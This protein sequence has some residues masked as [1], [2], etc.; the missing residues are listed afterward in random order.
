[1]RGGVI[2]SCKNQSILD[3]FEPETS[4]SISIKEAKDWFENIYLLQD[5][6]L[7]KSADSKLEREVDWVNA[8]KSELKDEGT[9]VI[10]PIKYKTDDKPSFV[11]WTNETAYIE[12]LVEYYFN[13][14]IEVLIVYTDE[15]GEKSAYL[16]QVAYDRYHLANEKIDTEKF[17]G[18]FLKADW[19]DNLLEANF[20]E[21]GE[22][23]LML[24]KNDSKARQQQCFLVMTNSYYT[25][26]GQSCG[27][28]CSEFTITLHRDYMIQCYGNGIGDSGG[29]IPA[30]FLP[31]G[32]GGSQGSYVY[33][34]STTN[35]NLRDAICNPGSSD[36]TQMNQNLSDALSAT[37][38]ASGVTG[39]T[40][41]KAE[42]ILKS[43]G[44]NIDD[45][46][47][48]TTAGRRFGIAGGGFGVARGI[49]GIF[50][51]DISDHDALDIIGGTIS[52]G[53][54]VTPVG[55]VGVAVGGVVSLA[56]AIY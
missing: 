18:W 3:Y 14:I 56:I 38:L 27:P 47:P 4:K 12:K 9:C 19:D 31:G 50:D 25:Y 2:L 33:T 15:K 21:N 8:R 11:T 1:M 34:T 37:G 44:A 32:S 41:N 22:H 30:E 43:I 39:W 51:G 28:N 42:A 36:R 48:L 24:E 55:W 13:P 20:Y 23:K 52:V 40:F 45:F 7:K 54:A 10:A 17:Y 49:I 26:S 6:N 35:F 29:G 53:L 5:R 46:R 16:S